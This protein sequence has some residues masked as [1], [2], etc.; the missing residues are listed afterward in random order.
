M[1]PYVTIRAV[2]ELGLALDCYAKNLSREG[3]YV[4]ASKAIAYAD[5]GSLAI[6]TWQ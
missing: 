6:S 5:I 1:F 4:G 3:L 2:N